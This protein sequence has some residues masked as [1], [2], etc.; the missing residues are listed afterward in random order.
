MT[1]VF[2]YGMMTFTLTAKVD[3]F[4]KKMRGNEEI[5][6]VPFIK[7]SSK[8]CSCK[9]TASFCVFSRSYADISPVKC[10]KRY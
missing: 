4:V 6:K 1:M 10:D 8:L 9:Q 5:V 2:V 7:Q 3:S